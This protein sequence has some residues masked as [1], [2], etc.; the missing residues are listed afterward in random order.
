[1]KYAL[2]LILSLGLANSSTAS[3]CIPEVKKSSAP[4]L[5]NGEWVQTEKPDANSL[6]QADFE[7]L[8]K[9]NYT[10]VF[11]GIYSKE[12]NFSGKKL[13]FIKTKNIWNGKVKDAVDIDVGKPP[14]DPECSTL[15]YGQEY[16]FFANLGG[17]NKPLHLKTFRKATPQL[18]ALLGKPNK[19]WLRGRLI[20]NR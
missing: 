20:Q 12:A 10:F 5:V 4:R 3:R 9:K 16:I 11:S 6:A 8:K 17:R 19:Q 7:Q 13:S 1:M 15:K 18:K 14:T 2:I